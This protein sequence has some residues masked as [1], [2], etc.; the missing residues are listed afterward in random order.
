[1]SRPCPDESDPLACLDVR[2]ITPEDRDGLAEAFARLSAETRRRRFLGPKPRLTA[3][4]LTYLTNVDHV[5][6][7]ALVAVDDEGEIVAVA[8]YAAGPRGGPTA[9]MAVTVADDRQ[10]SGIGSRLA[11]RIV[12]AARRNGI[13]SLTATT[14]WENRPALALLRR[15]GFRAVGSSGGLLDVALDLG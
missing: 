6:H 10:G 1:M 11:A 7:E 9:D 2:P 13:T 4:E 8:R 5:T 14:M 12:H 15:L 3:R